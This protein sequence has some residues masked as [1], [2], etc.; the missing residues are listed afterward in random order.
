MKMF[1]FA[2]GIEDL[3]ES[4]GEWTLKEKKNAGAKLVPKAQSGKMLM[5]TSV[6]ESKE[7]DKIKQEQ[8]R[9]I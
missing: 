7:F 3:T 8:A 2:I 9:L 4:L 5:P 1:G 6:V